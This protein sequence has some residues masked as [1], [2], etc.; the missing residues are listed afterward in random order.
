MSPQKIH[1]VGGGLVGSLAAIFADAGCAKVRTYIQSGN[2]L[3]T[4]SPNIAAKL[5]EVVPA[6]IAKQFGLRVPVIIRSAEEFA[7]L[8]AKNPYLPID[9]EDRS[10]HV[11]FLAEVP[12]KNRLLD[13]LRSPGDQFHHLGREVYLRLGKGVA[14][15]RLTNAYIDATLGTTSTLRNW[16]TIL[17]LAELLAAPD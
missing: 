13:P 2:V 12:Q 14:K 1:I 3:F 4:A 9:P 5:I 8:V 17:Q 6:R 16:R 7:V 10:L 15:T 11:A